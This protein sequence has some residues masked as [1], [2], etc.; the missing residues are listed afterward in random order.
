MSANRLLAIFPVM[1]KCSLLHNALPNRQY[2]HSTSAGRHGRAEACELAGPLF[3]GSLQ[4]LVGTDA[5]LFSINSHKEEQGCISP[6]YN[7]HIP[8]LS[9]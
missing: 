4:L 2:A 3:G 8:V 7:L 5:D 1:Q 6:V 9:E